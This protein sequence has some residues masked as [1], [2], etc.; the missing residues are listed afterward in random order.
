M[1]KIILQGKIVSYPQIKRHKNVCF[2]YS[3]SLVVFF[4]ETEERCINHK[5]GQFYKRADK[6][7]IAVWGP[8]SDYVMQK[9]TVGSVVQIEGVIRV[10]EVGGYNKP[11]FLYCG[12][13][14]VPY[15]KFVT[16]EANT[17]K[18]KKYRDKYY[19]CIQ[20]GKF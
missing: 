16:I 10:K 2:D 1:N 7:S 3:G 13:V 5:T 20:T 19:R 15:K 6:H 8:L 4:M 9:L 12:P 18:V 17:I 11:P 14:Y